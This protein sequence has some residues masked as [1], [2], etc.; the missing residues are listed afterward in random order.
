MEG[1]DYFLLERLIGNS[2]RLPEFK[3]VGHQRCAM[4]W[5]CGVGFSF[6]FVHGS[7]KMLFRIRVEGYYI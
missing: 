3:A 6:A 2:G 7:Q 1:L 5:W 4:S